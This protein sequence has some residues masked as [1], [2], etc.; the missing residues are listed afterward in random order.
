MAKSRDVF[1]AL[2]PETE[3]EIKLAVIR[4][5][6]FKSCEKF[7]NSFYFKIIVIVG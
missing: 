5:L 7:D 6:E 4:T 3:K 2:G 1:N